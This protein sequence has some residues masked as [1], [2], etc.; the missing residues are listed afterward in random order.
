MSAFLVTVRQAGHAPLT[1]TAIALDSC[2]LIMAAQDEFGPCAVSV[3]P[4]GATA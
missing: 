3:K 1:Y 2:A 4:A